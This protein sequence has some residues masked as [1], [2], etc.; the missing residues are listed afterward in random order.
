MIDKSG[1]YFRFRKLYDVLPEGSLSW[2]S[3]LGLDRSVSMDNFLN[4]PEN[5]KQVIIYVKNKF[6]ITIES[7]KIFVKSYK[8][9]RTTKTLKSKE[10]LNSREKRARPSGKIRLNERK[11]RKI[12]KAG[13]ILDKIERLNYGL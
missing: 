8:L 10:G 6:N 13:E 2:E 11:M 3:Y 1:G 9:L 5:I 12:N 4:S 7:S